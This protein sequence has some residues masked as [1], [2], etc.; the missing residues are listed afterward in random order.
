MNKEILTVTQLNIAAKELLEL[1]FLEIVVEGEISNFACPASGHWYFSLK[2]SSSQVR[3]AMFRQY[4]FRTKDRPKDGDLVQ[5]KAKVS[6]Y[7]ERGEYQLIVYKLELAGEGALR[8]KLETLLNKLRKEGLFLDSIK[9]TIP[10]FPKK[11]GIITSPTGAAV[12]DVL[13][14]INRRFRPSH[15]VIYPTEVQGKTAANSIISALNLAI[16]HNECDVLII[17]RGGGSIEDLW[18][19]NSEDLARTIF[20]CKI[21]VISAVGHEIDFTVCDYVS[22]LRAPT[23]SAAGEIVTKDKND[24]LRLISN[25]SR[26]MITSI[27]NNIGNKF[28]SLSH[29]EKR[30]KDPIVKIRLNRERLQKISDKLVYAVSTSTSNKRYEFKKLL[31]KLNATSPLATLDR[32]YSIATNIDT[33]KIVF[34]STSL[35]IQEHIKVQFKEGSAICSVEEIK[36]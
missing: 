12:K 20:S 6:L 10:E 19:F 1:S 27:V 9:K 8:K 22:D 29:I 7:P 16:A 13:S 23:P 35:K 2:D 26:K 17:T 21:P 31:A 14:V 24:I 4:N 34:S 3:C 15:V 28:I 18:C 30:I 33:N 11:I 25:R 5:V 36:S 32:G